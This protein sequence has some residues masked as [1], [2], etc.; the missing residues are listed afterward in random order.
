MNALEVYNLIK[1]D[2]DSPSV[3]T[4]MELVAESLTESSNLSLQE[5]L[6]IIPRSERTLRDYM[7]FLRKAIEYVHTRDKTNIRPAKK[8]QHLWQIYVDKVDKQIPPTAP[9]STID[10]IFA[11]AKLPDPTTSDTTF[12][13]RLSQFFSLAAREIP[14]CSSE[15]QKI[16]YRIT[17][18]ITP[19][20]LPT[21][22][23]WQGRTFARIKYSRDAMRVLES[24]DKHERD[25]FLKAL[26]L[27]SQNPTHPSLHTKR[28]DS[29][30]GRM[31][32]RAS[33]RIRFSWHTEEEG[34]FTV[35]HITDVI[36]KRG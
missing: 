23:I 32:S 3:K 7:T 27:L 6:E 24:L 30:E 36:V 26:M 18:L 20:W 34:D 33:L 25:Q 13:T 19:S 12:I 21:H 14:H 29:E 15:L 35:L 2:I 22:T 4:I 10:E 28:M 9:P 16:A 17:Q 8:F 1:N 11:Y 31:Y 5:L